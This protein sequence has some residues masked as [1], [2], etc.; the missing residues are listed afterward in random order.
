MHLATF[1]V[2]WLQH[3]RPVVTEDAGGAIENP[4]FGR[5][6]NPISTKGIDYAHHITA[7]PL[8]LLDLPPSLRLHSLT[9]IAAAGLPL[10]FLKNFFGGKIIKCSSSD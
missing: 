4:D 3:Y 1:I 8:R 6:D 10:I 9:L 2:H 7:R 5:S